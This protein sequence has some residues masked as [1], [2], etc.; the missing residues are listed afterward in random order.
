MPW[1]KSTRPRFFAFPS[2]R[3]SPVDSDDDGARPSDPFRDDVLL[4]WALQ[5]L[6]VGLRRFLR[7]R[8]RQ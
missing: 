8:S 2:W 5:R 6:R 7:D 1:L 3:F 4:A